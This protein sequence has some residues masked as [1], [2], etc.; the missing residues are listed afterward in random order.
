MSMDNNLFLD[1]K[2]DLITLKVQ[3]EVANEEGLIVLYSPIFSLYIYSKVEKGLYH[4]FEKHLDFYDYPQPLKK[5]LSS[6][7]KQTKLSGTR[8]AEHKENFLSVYRIINFDS[9]VEPHFLKTGSEL[10][11]FV[12]VYSSLRH[13]VA[14]GDKPSKV[15]NLVELRHC[16][17]Q[18]LKILEDLESG[19]SLRKA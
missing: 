6:F 8:Y 2:K 14:H 10:S 4:F 3:L 19:F 7:L 16:A 18:A 13:E 17:D 11:R 12:D 5:W 15:L 1:L 9:K